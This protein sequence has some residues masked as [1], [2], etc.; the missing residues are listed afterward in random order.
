MG[1]F[2]KKQFGTGGMKKE[3]P[4][5]LGLFGAKP[6]PKQKL[7]S[8]LKTEK[9]WKAT[10]IP[11]EKRINLGDKL[12][13]PKKIRGSITLKKAEQIYNK[14]RN[15]PKRSIEEFGLKN[16]AERIKALKLLGKL[17]GK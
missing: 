9:A 4:K 3:P 1:L 10:N 6:F 11:R 16:E 7:T 13:D 12:F 15:Y 2:G 5:P 8:W 17:L 14:I